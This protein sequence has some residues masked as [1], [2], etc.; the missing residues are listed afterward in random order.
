MKNEVRENRISELREREGLTQIQLAKELGVSRATIQNWE[1]SKSDMTGYSLMMVCN[2]FGVSPNEVYGTG[3][4]SPNW[5]AQ[6]EIMRIFRSVTDDGKRALLAA[7]RGIESSYQ[8]KNNPVS[9]QKS[10]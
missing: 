9:K 7:A 3:T 6:Q 8:V 4:P 10:A 1:S 5:D 2:R